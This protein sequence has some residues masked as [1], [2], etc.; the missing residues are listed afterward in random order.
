M[1]FYPIVFL[2]KAKSRMVWD[3]VVK[4][5][6]PRFGYKKVKAEEEKNWMMHYKVI[7][8]GNYMNRVGLRLLCHRPVVLKLFQ[9]AE[10]LKYFS[11][12]LV[13]KIQ[14]FNL[15]YLADH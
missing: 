15:A 9:Y 12:T 5:W 7:L 10:H 2:K 13:H 11:A 4:N 6:V 14:M 3:D 1:A 8:I